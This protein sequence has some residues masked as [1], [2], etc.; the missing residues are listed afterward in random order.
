[1]GYASNHQKTE[2]VAARCS[3]CGATVVR[4]ANQPAEVVCLIC[5]AAILNR[6]FQVRREKPRTEKGFSVL[7]LRW[8]T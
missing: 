2:N 1:M 4:D 8:S 6:I 3:S 5:Q 7:R